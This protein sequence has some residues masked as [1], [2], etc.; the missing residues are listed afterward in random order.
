M[1]ELQELQDLKTKLKTIEERDFRFMNPLEEVAF[2]KVL[3][4]IDRKENAIRNSK[5]GED[6]GNFMKVSL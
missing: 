5:P 6:Y 4:F 3:G 1:N 2:K